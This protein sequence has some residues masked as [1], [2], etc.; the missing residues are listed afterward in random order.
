METINISE[1]Q[2]KLNI[3]NKILS[4]EKAERIYYFIIQQC[5]PARRWLRYILRLSG[6]E[7]SI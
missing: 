6:K 2:K 1:E 3:K 4:A 7:E 5:R